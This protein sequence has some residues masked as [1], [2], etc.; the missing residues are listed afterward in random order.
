[1]TRMAKPDAP[2]TEPK[3]LFTKEEWDAAVPDLTTAMMAYLKQYRTPIFVDHGDH[4]EPWGSG[5]FIELDGRKYILTN[6]HVANTPKQIG[7]RLDGQEDM[8]RIS[9]N[10]VEQGWPWDLALLPVSD[11][12]WSSLDHRSALIQV[13][14]LALAH[15]PFP[16]EVFAVSGFAGERTK[17]LF[18]EMQFES[19]TSLARE[20]A[21]AEHDEIDRR[22]HFGVDYL[23]DLVTVVAGKGLPKPSGLSGSAIWNTCYVEAKAQGVEW[24]PS[25]AKVAG[26]VWGWPSGQG[27]LCVTKV[28]HVRSFLLAAIAKL[29]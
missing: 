17:F 20:A 14:Q 29:R 22:F 16:T 24:T 28:E 13:E 1:M 18:G 23:P 4:G 11:E 6:Q 25:L 19:T 2:S 9:G 21:L 8:P 3:P 7:F 15:T 5:S 27:V 26:V 12:I 10:Y